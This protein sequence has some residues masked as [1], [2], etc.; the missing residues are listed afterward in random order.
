M[1]QNVYPPLLMEAVEMAVEM[2]EQKIYFRNKKY[3]AW[4]VESQQV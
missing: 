4:R 3:D 1:F 2:K